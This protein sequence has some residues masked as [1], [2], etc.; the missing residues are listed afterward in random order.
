MKGSHTLLSAQKVPSSTCHLIMRLL[1]QVAAAAAA[2]GLRL[3]MPCALPESQASQEAAELPSQ[4]DPEAGHGTTYLSVMC[5][6]SGP[7]FAAFC[8]ECSSCPNAQAPF[9]YYLALVACLISSVNKVEHWSKLVCSVIRCCLIAD[10]W[11][12]PKAAGSEA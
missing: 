10:L 3:D 5:D 6:V 11:R 1:Q 7:P 8:I 2:A 12:R 4:E 9:W